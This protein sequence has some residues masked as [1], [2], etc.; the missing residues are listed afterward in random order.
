LL[1]V[2]G[3]GGGGAP[4]PRVIEV[5]RNHFGIMTDDS[6]ATAIRALLDR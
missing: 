4:G 6:A 2:P 1:V 3:R 5:D